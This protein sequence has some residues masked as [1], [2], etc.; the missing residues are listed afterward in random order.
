MTNVE[1]NEC[2]EWLENGQEGDWA[3]NEGRT[4]EVVNMAGGRYMLTDK[5]GDFVAVVDEAWRAMMYLQSGKV[6][7]NGTAC[8]Y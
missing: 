7:V 6:R 2:T 8:V 3:E 4:A 1:W 5:D